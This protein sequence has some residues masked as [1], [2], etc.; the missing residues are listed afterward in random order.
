MNTATRRAKV[1]REPVSG[2]YSEILGDKT[3]FPYPLLFIHGGGSTGDVFRITPD[4]RVSWADQLAEQGFCCWLTDWPGT[5]RSGYRD[6]LTLQYEDVVDGYTRLLRDVI[7]EPVIIVPHSMGGPTTWK[8]LE[9]LPHLV[10]GVLGIAAGYPGNLAAKNSVVLVDDGRTVEFTFGDTGV[11]FTLD[12]Q[13]PYTYD[14]DYVY[15]QAIG[16]S[17]LFPMEAVQELRSS[18]SAISPVMI[19]QRTGV[20]SGMPVVSNP[21]GFAGKQIRLM[22]GSDDPAHTLEIEGRTADFFRQWGAE[23]KVIWLPDDGI[24]GNGH[25]L[26]LERNSDDVLNIVIREL[27]AIADTVKSLGLTRQ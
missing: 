7:K 5:G 2:L 8:L 21:A 19:L 22:A 10:V 26:Q 11:H 25:F 9:T 13:K 3:S 23:A 15:K 17:K 1:G 20:I 18:F 27:R 4:G 14:D 24:V 16:A 12:R 6:L